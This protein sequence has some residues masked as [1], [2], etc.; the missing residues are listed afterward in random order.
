MLDLIKATLGQP[1][2]TIFY[3]YFNHGFNEVNEFSRSKLTKIKLVRFFWHL[4]L[5][6]SP[7]GVLLSTFETKYA[8]LDKVSFMEDSL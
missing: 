5:A 7:D 4:T 2:K 1:C 8:R 3:F 6:F